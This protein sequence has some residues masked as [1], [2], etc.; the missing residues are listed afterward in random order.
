MGRPVTAA[1]EVYGAVRIVARGARY[2]VLW[3]EDGEQHELSATTIETARQLALTVSARLVAGERTRKDTEFKH[4]VVK[5]LLPETGNRGER[6]QELYDGI[7]RNHIIP[8]LGDRRCR[9]LQDTDVRKFLHGLA[10]EGYSNS[11]IKHTM[12]VLNLAV[13]QGVREGVW[14]PMKHPMYDVSA[15]RAAGRPAD[16][17]PVPRSA[18]PSDAEVSRFLAEMAQLGSKFDLMTR[19]AAA[20]GLRWGELM[21]LRI[22]DIDFDA[23]VFHIVRAAIEHRGRLSFKVPKT[24]AGVRDVPIPTH[25][26]FACLE[27]LRAFIAGRKPSDV[28]FAGR[29]GQPMRRTNF[30]KKFREAADAAAFPERF[31][32]HSLR[33][34]AATRML[35]LG[36][37]LADVSATLGHANVAITQRL[38]VGGDA[39]TIDR[40]KAVL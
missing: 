19:I 36:I 25:G 29:T 31:T 13:R 27:E 3:S 1:L 32:W 34:Y 40:V 2:R 14:E 38:Y 22:S 33:H 23:G 28:V 16:L 18:V 21:G 35:R 9:N 15:P 17:A 6:C 4:L 20:T 37:S 11:T 10:A 5:A 39:E 7:A 26:D 12:K 30:S 8:A 24:E